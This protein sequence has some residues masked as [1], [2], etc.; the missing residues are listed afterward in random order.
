[1][2]RKHELGVG[3]LVIAAA[4][5]LAWMT[6]RVGAVEVGDRVN[7]T[8]VFEDAAGLKE[9]A[10]VSIAGVEVGTVSSLT[11]DF[12]RAL[13]GLSL[14][15]EANI[16][17]DVV[18]ALRARSV[19]GEKYIELVPQSREA[20]LLTSGATLTNTV[21]QLEIDQLVTQLGPL[22][23]GVDPEKLNQA[24][25][26]WLEAVAQDPERPARMLGDAET[27]LSNL[28]EASE[29]AP[30]LVN[31]ARGT[32]SEVR[33]LTR[34]GQKTLDRADAVLSDVEAATSGLPDQADRLPGLLDEVEATVSDTHEL[35]VELNGQTDQI[36]VILD[37][38]EEIDKWELRRI[39][40]EEGITVRLKPREIDEDE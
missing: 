26:P 34:E 20:E 22:L 18:V 29:D 21:G 32:L 13:V 28:R 37:N 24:L 8:A 5:I 25:D 10:A 17:E 39:L 30:A 23:D 38:L 27:L 7:A 11:V 19:L 2:S 1:M 35:V 14:D 4:G 40:R 6:L 33:T 12:D 9:G 31:E 16:R 36:E 15:P 3:V